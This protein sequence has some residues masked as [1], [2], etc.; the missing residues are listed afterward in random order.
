MPPIDTA[1]PLLLLVAI[2]AFL[3]GGVP[4]GL[5]MAKLFGLPDPRSIGSGNIG[6]T[7]VLRTGSKPA[8]LA[9]LVLDSSKGLIAVL[10]ARALAGEEAAQIAGLFAFLGH[11]FP[12]WLNFKGGKG[13][14]TFLGTLLGL[15]P[16][17]GLVAMGLWLVSFLVSRISSLSALIAT[18]CAPLA[19]V[20]LGVGQASLVTF[21]MALIVFWAHRANIKRLRAGTEPRVGQKE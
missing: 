6:A 12:V 10:V 16:L 5:V 7:N 18:A 13:V 15:A 3:L 20:F 21:V 11:I 14:A 9:T 17:L 2:A 1:I 19:A 8:A 4:F